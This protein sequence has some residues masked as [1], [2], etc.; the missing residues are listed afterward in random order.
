MTWMNKFYK[1]NIFILTGISLKLIR[2]GIIGI[3]RVSCQK[4]PSR[5]AYAWQIGPIWQET[6]DLL[7][8]EVTTKKTTMTEI[9]NT[10]MHQ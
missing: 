1:E 3:L 9:S 6:L 10:L 7:V 5:H 4:G 2:C 8:Y